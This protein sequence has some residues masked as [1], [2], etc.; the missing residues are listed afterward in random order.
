[1]KDWRKTLIGPERPIIEAMR[2]IDSGA[3]QIALVA[4]GENRLLGLVTD[5]DIRRG[6]LR[7]IALD[8]P[9]HVIMNK[10]FTYARPDASREQL[11]HLMREKVLLHIPV[12]EESGVIANLVQLRD[13]VE[14]LPRENWV[15]LMAGGLGRRLHPLT[16]DC[17]KPLLKIGERPILETII[18]NFSDYGFR[19]YF[20]SVNYKSEMIED[21]FGDGHRWGIHIDYIREDAALG[22]A[23]ALSLLPV[24]PHKPFVVM[25]ADV[26]T[27]VN[28]NHFLD[29]HEAHQSMATIGVKDYHLEVPYGVIKTDQH[30][31]VGIDEKPVQHFFVNAGIYILEPEILDY[32][33]RNLP[34]DMPALLDEVIA[35][36]QTVSVFPIREY[37]VDVGKIDDYE[38]ASGEYG[39]HF[40]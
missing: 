20:I 2:I 36:G 38:K 10:N 12:L 21:Y 19:K 31:L 5:G 11:I 34:L 17:P 39:E 14:L 28:M 3:L 6:I 30:F 4:D 16:A 22:T 24:R 32:I 8:Q 35:R 1:M 25:N 40:E 13:V 15:I 23:G 33:P 29:F 7:G 26:L 27:T 18:K 9:V 37:W